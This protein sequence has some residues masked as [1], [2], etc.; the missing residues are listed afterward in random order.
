MCILCKNVYDFEGFEFWKFL[1]ISSSP[2]KITFLPHSCFR[3]VTFEL[4]LVILILISL[5]LRFLR[6]R[7]LPIINIVI[8]ILRTKVVTARPAN[9]PKNNQGSTTWGQHLS[10][11][12][13][14]A[15]SVSN[16]L[17]S[18]YFLTSYGLFSGKQINYNKRI[19]FKSK[20]LKDTSN[21]IWSNSYLMIC[22]LFDIGGYGYRVRKW[23]EDGNLSSDS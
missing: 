17:F 9:I 2:A 11:P 5:L 15:A 7:F 21:G 22:F 23:N 6:R 3:F 4:G 14:S 20:T 16:F 19:I 12:P 13:L 18:L 1:N 8:C 10:C